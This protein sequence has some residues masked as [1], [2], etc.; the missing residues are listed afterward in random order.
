MLVSWPYLKH[1]HSHHIDL[2]LYI[3]HTFTGLYWRLKDKSVG[4][5]DRVKLARYIWK[6]A[7]VNFPNK[8]Q[9]VLD[10]LCL[11]LSGKIR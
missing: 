9:V 11:V 1:V 6:E 8:E 7:S 4:W 2:R 5:E 10:W 3:V